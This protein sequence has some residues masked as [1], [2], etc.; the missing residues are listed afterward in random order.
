MI[1]RNEEACL[2][3]C[4]K[5][6]REYVDEIIIV[7]TGSTDKTIE[8]AAGYGARIYHHPWENDFSKHRNQS[9]AYA[10]GDWI[11]Q[12]DADEELFAEDGAM[13]RSAIREGK[14]D[15]FHCRFYDMKKDGAVH[16]VFYL[17]RL[18]RNRMGMSYVR[19][20]HNQLRACG[21]GAYSGIRIR[22]YGYDLS[23]EQMEAKHVR[24]TTLLQEMLTS[25]PEDVYSVYQLSASYSMHREFDKA[26]EYGERALAIMRRKGLRND[27]F[28]I[29]FYSVA[30][31]YNALGRFDDAERVCIE[32]LDLFP[33]HMDMCHL[34]ATIYFR[35]KNADLCQAISE[36]YLAIYDAFEKNPLV[37]G[38]SYC[39]S[40][41]K[42][43]EIYFGLACIHFMKKDFAGA[44]DLF[45]KSFED[46]GKKLEEAENVC[47]F[48]F[49]QQMDDKALSW[50]KIAYQAGLVA[51]KTP[52]IMEEHL[53]LYMKVGK[54]C[55]Q[56]DELQAAAD[57]LEKAA[58]EELTVE[59][60]LEK[61][62]LQ[63]GL[64]WRVEATDELLGSLE[65]LMGMLDMQTRRTLQ[66]VHDL[67]Q[68]VYDIAEAF[69][70]RRQWPLAETALQLALQI[71]PALFDHRKFERMLP[72]E[73]QAGNHPA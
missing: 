24:T 32:A 57:C 70:L 26:A 58:D 54:N 33:M 17:I 66:S 56:Q 22:H 13:L 63:V 69:C 52:A 28:L 23:V 5:S 55:L 18:F 41:A 34:L 47:R 12:M 21:V 51:D 8:I 59:E 49:G 7:D 46:S 42:R 71:A 44:D 65:S 1:V 15:H 39:H 48:Y 62:L 11:V 72:G 4:L 45:R 68:I 27:F 37:L 73:A 50:L 38:S 40:F 19:K 43:N 20:V 10:T 16:G 67:G 25:D 53:E 60:Q 61:R 36:R 64:F 29:V 14:A 9:L 6:V 35:Q 30:Q 31:G 2:D 3:R